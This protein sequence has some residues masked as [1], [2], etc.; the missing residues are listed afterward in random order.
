MESNRPSSQPSPED[1]ELLEAARGDL[2]DAL[3]SVRNLVQLLH[4]M[5]VGPKA[6][7]AV[8]PAV[9]GACEPIEKSMRVLLEVIAARLP[10]SRAADELLSWSVPRAHQIERELARAFKR[11]MNARTRLDL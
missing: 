5:R 7:V 8:L 9:H 6:I 3:G 2:R 1:R 4:S 11:L 10:S